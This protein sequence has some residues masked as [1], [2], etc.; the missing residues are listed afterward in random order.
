MGLG[1]CRCFVCGDSEEDRR[2]SIVINVDYEIEIGGGIM[3][4][5]LSIW[6]YFIS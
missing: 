3:D 2:R 5:A 4:G 1:Y 6:T